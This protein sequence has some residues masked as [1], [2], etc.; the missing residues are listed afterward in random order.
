MW[1]LL[2]ASVFVLLIFNSCSLFDQEETIPGILIISS[3]EVIEDNPNFETCFGHKIR[4]IEVYV[5]GITQGIYPINAPIPIFEEGSVDV[6]IF[7]LVYASGSSQNIE[8][9]LFLQKESFSLDINF[10]E[11]VERDIVFEYQ[12]NTVFRLTEFFGLGNQFN[13]DIDDDEENTLTVVMDD[14][15]Q[16]NQVGQFVLDTATN[17]AIVTTPSLL[18]NLTSDQAYL[19]LDYYSELDMTISF[20]ILQQNSTNLE[21]QDLYYIKPKLEWNKLYINMTD[22][23]R[24]SNGIKFQMYLS[25]SLP[26]VDEDGNTVYSG[27]AYL[28]NIRIL[29]Y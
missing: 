28:D 26:L 1:R 18:E 14:Y 16:D 24:Q 4:N 15:C 8:P 25:A 22:F 7:P 2:C 17:L 23:I 5:N 10:G 21:I 13:I 27:K 12:P 11:V 29:T 20:A 6:E 3:V 9:H 19:E